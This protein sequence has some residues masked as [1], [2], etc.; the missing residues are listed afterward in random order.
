[1]QHSSAHNLKALPGCPWDASAE[2][3]HIN[4]R[5][6]AV[7]HMHTHKLAGFFNSTASMRPCW[8]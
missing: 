4:R 8:G 6:L 3:T 1:M 2:G 5:Q 7:T